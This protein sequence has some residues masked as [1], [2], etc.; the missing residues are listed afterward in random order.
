[1]KNTRFFLSLTAAQ[2]RKFMA[3]A[4]AYGDA[5][6]RGNDNRDERL[7]SLPHHKRIAINDAIALEARFLEEFACNA[8]CKCYRNI[9]KKLLEL[10]QLPF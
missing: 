9:S 10:Q 3:F 2:Q 4:S 5:Y 1:M 6:A 7:L 8:L